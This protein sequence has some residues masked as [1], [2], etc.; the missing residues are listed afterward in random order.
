MR[1]TL[2]FRTTCTQFLPAPTKDKTPYFTGVPNL[3]EVKSY[4]TPDGL[5]NLTDSLSEDL[6][7]DIFL[8]ILEAPPWSTNIVIPSNRVSYNRS[9]HLLTFRL[10]KGE[11]Y[12]LTP[13]RPP[14]S[15]L[16]N[17]LWDPVA[18][19]ITEVPPTY[20]PDSLYWRQVYLFSGG[21]QSKC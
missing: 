14:A 4:I 19:T 6:F 15:S 8:R 11:T 21:S 1:A 9:K 12:S 18:K 10:F 16:S 3:L 13:P 20:S 5:F 2:G 17:I 7:L